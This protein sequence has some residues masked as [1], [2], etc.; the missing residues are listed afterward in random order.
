MRIEEKGGGG[1]VMGKVRGGGGRKPHNPPIPRG[2]RGHRRHTWKEKQG[3]P[4]P[5]YLP[6]KL[7]C[8]FSW[9][10]MTRKTQVNKTQ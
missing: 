1:Q 7:R 10:C 3:R 6:Q 5:D 8:L 2:R 9:T 4:E